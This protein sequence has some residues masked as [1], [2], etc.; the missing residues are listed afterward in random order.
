[1]QKIRERP[2]DPSGYFYLAMVSW[3]K[4]TAGF[5]T[6]EMVEE[7]GERIDETISV[8]EKRIQ[9]GDADSFCYFYLGGALGFKAR[10]LLMQRKWFSSFLL[11]LRAVEALKT[12]LEMNPE[13]RDVLLGIG[14]FDYYTSRLSGTLKFLSYFFLHKGDKE[15]GLRKLHLVA[16]EA[17][18]S[19]AE[20][21]SLLISIYLFM[22]KDHHKALPMIQDFVGRFRNNPRK[23]YLEGVTH[24]F[25]GNYTKCRNTVDFLYRKSL[26]ENSVI[27]PLLWQRRAQYL[28][29]SLALFQGDCAG[30]RSKLERI[31]SSQDPERDPAMVAWPLVKMGLSYD[32]EEDRERA[33]QYYQRVLAMENGAGAQF[34][35]R[36]Y[37][38]KPPGKKETF[39]CY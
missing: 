24:I 20:A 32:L 35:A 11:A 4:I 3:S 13:N 27:H 31:L 12:S 6:P 8:A 38:H 34:L 25:S 2:K 7:Y 15:E 29:A 26:K 22:E 37:I 1:M 21:K 33:L 5:W 23:R 14:V 28:E 17:I 36:K 10:F 16:E 9:E 18:Y 19:S 30:A 39:L